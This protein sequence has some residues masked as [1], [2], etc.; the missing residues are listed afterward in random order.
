[1]VITDDDP[2]DAERITRSSVIDIEHKTKD[3]QTKTS[4]L[5]ADISRSNAATGNI[6]N[7]TGTHGTLELDTV[8]SNANIKR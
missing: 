3:Q 7:A 1:M 8:A 4:D 5:I 6:R 2:V